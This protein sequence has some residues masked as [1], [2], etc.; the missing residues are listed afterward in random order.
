MKAYRAWKEGDGSL[1]SKVIEAIVSKSQQRDFEFTEVRDEISV[2]EERAW[3]IMAQGL[4][5]IRAWYDALSVLEDGLKKYPSSL[6]FKSLLAK[7]KLDLEKLKEDFKAQGQDNT[8][9]Q[10]T[11]K[12]G[13]VGRVAYP[14]IVPEELTRGTKAIKKLKARFESAAT[15]AAV[16]PSG[17][18]GTTDG[19]YG[20]FAT[21]DIKK[22]E[23][24]LLDR[25]IFS[26]YNTLGISDC[27]ACCQPLYGSKVTADC[28][29]ARFCTES[30][31]AEALNAYHRV[32][33]GKD[34]GWLYAACKD[35]GIVTNEMI[36]LHMVKVLATA[37][38]QNAKPLKVA[39]VGTLT[40]DYQKPVLSFFK[41]FDNIT[42]PIKVLQILGVD[43]FTDMRFDSWALQT[44]F[45][46]IETNKQGGVFGKRR[47]SGINTLFSVFN[48]DCNPGA[49]WHG[50]EAGGA[51]EVAAIRHITKGEEICV[52]YIEPW[53]PEAERRQRVLTHIGRICECVRCVQEREAVAN[54]SKTD[55]FDV[56]KI[57][58]DIIDVQVASQMRLAGKH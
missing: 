21:D 25:S 42:A 35:A 23:R 26:C 4:M 31:K 51:I 56:S 10:N 49:T 3:L 45:L 22:G 16:A 30:C 1:T 28:C 54:G 44:L 34:F 2:I 40:A 48:H 15:K 19:N 57:R 55:A 9:V 33:C 52:S 29:K 39:C 8:T 46:R 41:L 11:T 36:P 38:Q 20:V 5:C 7:L 32:L 24:I 14:W 12:R 50:V 53:V 43:I 27:S 13:R 58:Q 37:I 47:H 17:L 6:V 18:G